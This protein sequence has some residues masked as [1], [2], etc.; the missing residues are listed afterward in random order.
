MNPPT[1]R[2]NTRAGAA[3]QNAVIKSTALAGLAA[4]FFAAGNAQAAMEVANIA[5]S[6]GRLGT[7]AAL[8]VPVLG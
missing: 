1:P 3:L 7:I 8:A 6:D 4:S 2:T 5:A